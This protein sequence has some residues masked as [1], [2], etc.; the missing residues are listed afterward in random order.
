MINGSP[1]QYREWKGWQEEEEVKKA[2]R[3]H[4]PSKLLPIS[5]SRSSFI[6]RKVNNWQREICSWILTTEKPYDFSGGQ[7]GGPQLA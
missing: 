1:D 6:N 4:G 5:L 3:L 7:Q 2:E